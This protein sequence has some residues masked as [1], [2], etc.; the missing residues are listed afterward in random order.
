[1]LKR[2]MGEIGEMVSKSGERG[3]PITKEGSLVRRGVKTVSW[4]KS[5]TMWYGIELLK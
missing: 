5:F 1:M 2:D 4:K 3:I